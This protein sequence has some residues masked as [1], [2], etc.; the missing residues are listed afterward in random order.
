MNI[1]FTPSSKKKAFCHPEDV[2]DSLIYWIYSQ[3]SM[4]SF[5]S[6]SLW[7]K[8][9]AWRA[10]RFWVQLA[11]RCNST[12]CCMWQILRAA[13]WSIVSYKQWRL[14]NAFINLSSAFD[15]VDSFC[16]KLDY[17]CKSPRWFSQFSH[18]VTSRSL[19]PY[20]LQHDR[21]PCPSPTPGDY[22]NSCPSR[23]WYH[24]TI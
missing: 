23:W 22:S 11:H 13:T 10:R 19:W 2:T 9:L 20:G 6:A 3:N 8:H 21:V 1:E 24:P 5:F 16:T 4:L 12:L 17:L 14:Y 15:S 7:N 18:S